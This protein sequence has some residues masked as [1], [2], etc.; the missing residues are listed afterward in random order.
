[1]SLIK[2]TCFHVVSLPNAWEWVCLPPCK[3]NVHCITGSSFSPFEWLFIKSLT[4]LNSIH[5]NLIPLLPPQNSK[6]PGCLHTPDYF[7]PGLWVCC[8]CALNP[9]SPAVLLGARIQ[10]RG[11]Q[12]C[13]LFMQVPRTMVGLLQRCPANEYQHFYLYSEMWRQM[14]EG[15]RGEKQPYTEAQIASY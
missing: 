15:S 10:R 12:G 5:Q 8:Y 9:H 4:L 14:G 13:W 1:M 3:D 11:G 7:S 6:L 2:T